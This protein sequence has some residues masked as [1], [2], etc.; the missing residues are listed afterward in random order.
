MPNFV[1]GATSLPVARS[2][3]PK[4]SDQMTLPL[5]PTAT[6]APGAAPLRSASR[7]ASPAFGRASLRS[8]FRTSTGASESHGRIFPSRKLRSWALAM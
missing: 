3:A 4:P 2:R 8:V 1:P 5:R 6:A 7:T